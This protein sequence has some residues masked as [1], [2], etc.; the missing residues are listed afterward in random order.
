MDDAI[1]HSPPFAAAYAGAATRPLSALGLR[2]SPPV[3]TALMDQALAQPDLLSLAAGFTDNT[4]LP[5]DEVR[6]S[7]ERLLGGDVPVREVLQYGTNQGRP[8]LREAIVNHLSG[9]LPFPVDSR[10]VLVTNGSQQALYL[11]VQTL[12]DPGD[13][14]LVEQPSYF[15]FLELL[16]GLGV[17]AVSMPVDTDGAIDPQALATLLENGSGDFGPERIKG[18][19][20]VSY[21]ANPSSRCLPE[22]MKVAVGETLARLRPDV[23]VLEDAAYRDLYFENPYPARACIE[24]DA[25]RAL[26]VIYT[27]TFTKPLATGVKV[28][29]AV[30]N[31][32]AWLEACI[33]TK[34]HQDFGTANLNQAI[35]ED[36]LA[37]GAY[38]G[39]LRREQANYLRKM[40]LLSSALERHGL[41]EAG[42]HWEESDGGLLLWLT[43][44][45]H[46]DTGQTGAFCAACLEAGVLYVPGE[47]CFAP[48]APKHFVRL[49]FGAIAE[50][51]IEEAARRFCTVARQF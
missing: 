38:A 37:R 45:A 8:G 9:G 30:A 5:A 41:R 43:A 24:L 2:A 4:I 36:I 31:D 17:R 20:L 44:P 21:F 26:R 16:Q 3:I 18:V 51:S 1:S 34:G 39:I 46:I 33:F 11:A 14:I 22:A 23:A 19:Y 28:G 10:N 32:R 25:F 42:W 13:V 48:P 7:V 15:V 27:G 6:T 12:C 50:A 47:L 29:Y 40:C 35:V 49:S